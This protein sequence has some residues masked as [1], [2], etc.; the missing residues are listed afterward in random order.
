MPPNYFD[1]EKISGSWKLFE[2][3]HLTRTIFSS[4]SCT[5]AEFQAIVIEIA[6]AYEKDEDIIKEITQLTR[7][8]SF[9]QGNK[10]QAMEILPNFHSSKPKKP[11]ASSRKRR[12]RSEDEVAPVPKKGKNRE[13]EEW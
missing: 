11:N 6:K 9:T 7:G 5:S 4:G 2:R 8:E 3:A 12:S 10:P 1:K 13:G